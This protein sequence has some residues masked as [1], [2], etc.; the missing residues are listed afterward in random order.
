MKLKVIYEDKDIIICFKPAGI[1]SQTAGISGQD[2]VSII[3]N[4]FVKAGAEK[5][6]YLGV[7]HRLDQ[8]VSGLLVFAKNKKSA[9]ALSKQIQGGNANKDYIA[10]CYG[11]FQEKKG[12][13]I[14]YVKKDEKIKSACAV[15]EQEYLQ[16]KKQNEDISS[17]KKAIL[18]YEVA[19]E[20][21][22]ASLV[23]IH[24]QTGRFHQ[25]RVQF[26][27][28][29]HSLLGDVKY[30]TSESKQVSALK[31][32]TKVALCAYRLVINHPSGGKKME[33]LLAQEDMPDWYTI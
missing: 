25:I 23:K 31:R 32:I 16:K 1:A 6:P 28:C 24:L 19:A 11:R 20:Y 26:S 22:D 17:Y 3:K 12:T 13:L 18:G 4:Y 21:E 33:F 29:G 27:A 9:A 7:I 10:L 30:G 14:H 8:P 15:S 2:M 5:N